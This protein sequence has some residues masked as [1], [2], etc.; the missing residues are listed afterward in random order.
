[1]S[2]YDWSGHFTSLVQEQNADAYQWA[3]ATKAA[4]WALHGAEIPHDYLVTIFANAVMTM[5]DR[6]Y[7][8]RVR[9]L[10][11]KLRETEK[12]RDEYGAQANKDY[13]RC[14]KLE[15]ENK[16]LR[17]ELG[18]CKDA[19]GLIRS[20]GYTKNEDGSVIMDGNEFPWLER[21]VSILQ[22]IFP[23]TGGNVAR[24]PCSEQDEDNVEDYI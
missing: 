19:Y 8:S 6:V 17:R 22:K 5:H 2:G 1:M 10:E 23:V 18:R 21:G 4:L 9:P 13:K 12:N 14:E 20:T 15:A 11:E 7:N 24:N 3:R 16:R